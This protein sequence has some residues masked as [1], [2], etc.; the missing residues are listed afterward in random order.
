M[1]SSKSIGGGSVVQLE[2]RGRLLETREASTDEF[3][4][5]FVILS[6]LLVSGIDKFSPLRKCLAFGRV[7]S[8]GL[9]QIG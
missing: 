1:T 8:V 4:H 2:I 5:L 3:K 7:H 6:K 9:D